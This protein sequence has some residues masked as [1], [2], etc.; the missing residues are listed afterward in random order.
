MML[1]FLE[2]LICVFGI[3]W[4]LCFVWLLELFWKRQCLSNGHGIYPIA[5]V[6]YSYSRMAVGDALFCD[7]ILC[8]SFVRKIFVQHELLYLSRSCSHNHL[9]NTHTWSGIKKHTHLKPSSSCLSLTQSHIE[10]F[11]KF[12]PLASSQVLSTKEKDYQSSTVRKLDGNTV[13]H[14]SS[15][16]TQWDTKTSVVYVY[17]IRAWLY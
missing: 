6:S 13:V 17:G 4:Y 11:L 9:T 7:E 3:M 1:N 15:M 10:S 5:T 2:V 8:P 14:F 16:V 12:W